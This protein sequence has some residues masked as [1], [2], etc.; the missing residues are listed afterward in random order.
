MMLV[1]YRGNLLIFYLSPVVFFTS[2][3][4][5]SVQPRRR[6][7]PLDG[8]VQQDLQQNSIPSFFTH[9]RCTVYAEGGG[10]S[11]RA[12]HAASQR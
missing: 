2:Y 1:Y 4:T 12:S 8:R 11:F 10:S 9:S 6:G 5:K 3:L 7:L